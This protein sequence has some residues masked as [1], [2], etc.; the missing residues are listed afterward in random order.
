[1]QIHHS[2]LILDACCVLN[3]CASGDFLGILKSIPAEVVV[4]TVVQEYE[5]RTLQ[6]LKEEENQGAIQ[7]EAA[8]EQGLLI[9]VDFESEQE[10]ESYVNYA[11]ILGDDGESATCAIATDDKRAI[12]FIQKEASNI[13]ILSTPEIIKHWSEVASLDDSD[14]R[15]ILNTIRLKGRYLPAKT[16]PLRSWWLGFLK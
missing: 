15:N 7:F 16:H 14:L 13:Q 1:M 6:R 11:A 9:V 5:L 4:T 10:E 12:S 3:F 2:H 8:I